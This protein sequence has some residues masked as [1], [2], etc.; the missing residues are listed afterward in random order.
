MKTLADKLPSH[1]VSFSTG[2]SSAITVEV[3]DMMSKQLSL[4]S[5]RPVPPLD[6]PIRT[7]YY[8]DYLIEVELMSLSIYGNRAFIRYKDGSRRCVNTRDLYING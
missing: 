2:L 1:I 5:L 3:T 6:G 4:F 7:M 8:G